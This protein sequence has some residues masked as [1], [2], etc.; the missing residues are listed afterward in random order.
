[1]DIVNPERA[2]PPM[3]K[4]EEFGIMAEDWSNYGRLVGSGGA[5][6]KIDAYKEAVKT[7]ERVCGNQS[8][9]PH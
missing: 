8:T 9:S 3:P 2:L 4:P 6:D 7:W 1:M 5:R